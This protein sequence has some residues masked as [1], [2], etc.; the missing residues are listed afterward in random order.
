MPRVD[1]HDPLEA[2]RL[3]ALGPDAFHTRR[4]FLQRSAVAMAS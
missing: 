1:V 2:K 4:D 3:E